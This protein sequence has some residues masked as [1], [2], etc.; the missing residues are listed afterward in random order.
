MARENF[1]AR[2]ALIALEEEWENFGEPDMGLSDSSYMSSPKPFKPQSP[3]SYRD[4]QIELSVPED[5]RFFDSL[6]Q[7]FNQPSSTEYRKAVQTFEITGWSDEY[8]ESVIWPG[9]ANLLLNL[10]NLSVLDWKISQPIP[11]G[12]SPI[13]AYPNLWYYTEAS[14]NSTAI[15]NRLQEDARSIIG[16][17]LLYSINVDIENSYP[18]DP[19]SM[20]ILFEI[21]RSNPPNLRELQLRLSHFGCVVDNEIEAF[22]FLSS[23]F[24]TDRENMT[25]IQFPP[26]EK[27]VVEGYDFEESP[28]GGSGWYR[29]IETPKVDWRTLLKFPWDKLPMWLIDQIGKYRLGSVNAIRY[30]P[31]ERLPSFDGVSNLDVWLKVMDWSKL[32]TL[33]MIESSPVAVQKLGIAGVLTGLKELKIHGMRY[34]WNYGAKSEWET[35][36]DFLDDITS[37]GTSLTSLSIH[38]QLPKQ[39]ST[40]VSVL[41]SSSIEDLAIDIPSLPGSNYSESENGDWKT[42]GIDPKISHEEIYKAFTPLARH[43][44]L[45]SVEFHVPAPE[46]WWHQVKRL[47]RQG[48][49]TRSG[50][51][52]IIEVDDRKFQDQADMMEVERCEREEEELGRRTRRLFEWMNGER[53]KIG[54]NVIE[55]LRVVAG[56][57]LLWGK[58]GVGVE[59]LGRSSFGWRWRGESGVWSCWT[60][61]EEEATKCEG[62][63]RWREDDIWG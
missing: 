47:K 26:L 10:P 31:I 35:V 24:N 42:D 9:I 46:C 3:E 16:S 56:R 58:E 5:T 8:T 2:D 13:S 4:F 6:L 14:E 60:G 59:M 43:P 23:E 50:E 25:S 34:P 36:V 39:I 30:I 51:V 61:E 55:R 18:T 62:G 19:A 63:R 11:P 28:D 32:K 33:H 7:F 41:N 1:D 38:S 40:L 29:N 53:E 49:Y 57:E 37:N 52:E 12:Y 44:Q 54:E 20:R 45:K 17:P 15:A 48:M 27:L 22:P 21:L